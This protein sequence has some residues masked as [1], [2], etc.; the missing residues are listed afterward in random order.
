MIIVGDGGVGKST[1]VRALATGEFQTSYVA[2]IGVEVNTLNVR[3]ILPQ[4]GANDIGNDIAVSVWDTAGQEKFGGLR[5]GY[6]IGGEMAIVM[7]DGSSKTGI[8]NAA[9]W[10]RDLRRVCDNIPYV[11]ICNKSD[12]GIPAA[13]FPLSVVRNAVA[14]FDLSVQACLSQ[15]DLPTLIAPILALIR[16]RSGSDSIQ[17]A[18]GSMVT[19]FGPDLPGARPPVVE[20]PESSSA[21]EPAAPPT[22][23]SSPFGGKGG[24][25]P[26]GGEKSPWIGKKVTKS[27]FGGSGGFGKKASSPGGFEKKASSPGGFGKK[28]SSFGGFGT[29]TSSSGGFG[30][31]TSPAA[32]EKISLGL[33]PPSKSK[34]K[35]FGAKPP[36]TSAAADD[37]YPNLEEEA[38]E[39]EALNALEPR[40]PFTD[41]PQE[42]D[43]YRKRLEER[44]EEIAGERGFE[45]DAGDRARVARL[46]PKTLGQTAWQGQIKKVLKQIHP[47]SG[48]AVKAGKVI[49]DMLVDV[50]MQLVDASS[51][52]ANKSAFLIQVIPEEAPEAE[53][54]A[55]GQVVHHDVIRALRLVYPGELAK[56]AVSE[57]CKAVNKLKANAGENP[58]IT[59]ANT[60]AGLTFSSL[61]TRNAIRKRLGTAVMT[62][63]SGLPTFSV[64]ALAAIT[65][66]LEYLC[67]EI[68]ELSG[69]AARDNRKVRIIERHIQLAIRNDEELNKQFRD[70]VI[71]GGGVL[72]NIHRVLLPQ[73]SGPSQSTNRKEGTQALREIRAMQKSTDLLLDPTWFS[74]IVH[75]CGSDYASDLDFT[76]EAVEAL[77]HAAEA[78]LVAMFGDANLIATTTRNS[79]QI[80]LGDVRA[81]VR[82]SQSKDPFYHMS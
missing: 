2:T 73:K 46:I 11:V 79:D 59:Q 80:S 48:I 50:L 9:N 57:A 77:Q 29:K 27:G 32:T 7:A 81:A 45:L 61:V 16:T 43:V 41:I 15:R 33:N 36:P 71:P 64:P 66:A 54:S 42:L 69:N 70:K 23:T 18:I 60:S 56:H 17:L 31:K 30:T 12:T 52:L 65:A 62:L 75:E 6:Y 40:E 37:G 24:S 35:K 44:L 78:H 26:F 51:K 4:E 3:A 22:S 63:D 5:D 14:V 19:S 55:L 47:D 8:A 82:I 74:H 1:Y 49:Q 13:S 34:K 53:G 58:T 72:P 76:A 25:S 68:L 21:D 20:N 38:A 10:V 28:T 39:L 67:A